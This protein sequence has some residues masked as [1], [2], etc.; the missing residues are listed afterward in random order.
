MYVAMVHTGHKG[1]ALQMMAAGK[2]VLIEK[3]MAMNHAEAAR[4]WMRPRD[5]CHPL[6][7]E[8]CFALLMIPDCLVL[9][10]KCML[11][12]QALTGS[13]IRHKKCL[14]KYQSW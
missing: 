4:W 5:R 2:H 1:A 14:I 3:P 6:L 9:T 7:N 13:N 12:S 11:Q 10:G 8:L